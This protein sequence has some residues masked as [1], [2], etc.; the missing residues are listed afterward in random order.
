M[1]IA[2][3]RPQPDPLV[4]SPVRLN[5]PDAAA[6]GDAAQLPAGP[7]RP[8]RTPTGFTPP[9]RQLW[10]A[11]TAMCDPTP[12]PFPDS[13][14]RRWTARS[15]RR[16]SPSFVT[17]L[18]KVPH[19]R[20]GGGGVA[21]GSVAEGAS[22]STRQTWTA[23]QHDGPDHLE[24][25]LIRRSRRWRGTCWTSWS[26]GSGRW[27]T[28]GGGAAPGAALLSWRRKRRWG[29]AT[30]RTA[31]REWRRGGGRASGQSCWTGT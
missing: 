25:W 3:P 24:L 22:L 9:S 10:A 18:P 6:D 28:T 2:P 16:S 11:E 1:P 8:Q 23:L 20:A 26:L 7:A 21:G 12:L 29:R 5:P 19:E 27:R 14:H 31:G 4:E 15:L 17:A 13:F 30:R